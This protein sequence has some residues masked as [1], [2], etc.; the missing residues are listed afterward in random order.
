MSILGCVVTGSGGRCVKWRELFEGTPSFSA[1]SA[2]RH[3]AC[4]YVPS[5]DGKVNWPERVSGK[6]PDAIESIISNKRLAD[7]S[8]NFIKNHLSCTQS[9]DI[10]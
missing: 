2:A 7:K 4:Q 3:R 9:M 5:S 6:Y 8:W 1:T 10:N